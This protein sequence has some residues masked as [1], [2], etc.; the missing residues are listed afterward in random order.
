[1]EYTLAPAATTLMPLI[2]ALGDWWE[3]TLPERTQSA[4]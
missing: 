3:Q 2:D 4:A 1:V